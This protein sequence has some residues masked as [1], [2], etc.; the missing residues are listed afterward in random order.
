VAGVFDAA[1]EQA[2]AQ[3]AAPTRAAAMAQD[4]A[5]ASWRGDPTSTSPDSFAVVIASCTYQVVYRQ[6]P[7]Y[8]SHPNPFTHFKIVPL[9]YQTL[10]LCLDRYEFR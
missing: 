6:L 9:L 10:S 2:V 3:D 1:P 5:P 8:L 4:E 7:P